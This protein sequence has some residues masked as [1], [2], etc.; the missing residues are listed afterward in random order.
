MIIKLWVDLWEWLSQEAC[1]PGAKMVGLVLISRLVDIFQ[2]SEERE[3]DEQ[4]EIGDD[5][6]FRIWAVSLDE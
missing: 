5:L 4:L 1:N 2:I 3:R 6:D